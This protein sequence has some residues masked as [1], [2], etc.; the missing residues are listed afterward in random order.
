[1][2]KKAGSIRDRE[3]LGN[4]LY[5][6]A[7]RVAVRARVDA[8]RRK[9]QERMELESEITRDTFQD[10][11][12]SSELKAV[13][14]A[15]LERLPRRYRAPIVLCD[16]EGQT[17]EQAASALRCPVGT[18]KSR[19]SRGRD[20]LRSRLARRGLPAP[21]LDPSS[22]LASDPTSA[23]SFKLL[24][25]TIKA[26]TGL[27]TKGT[28]TAGPALLAQGVI[29]TMAATTPKIASIVLLTGVAAIGGVW[30]TIELG[31][32]EKTSGKQGAI[33]RREVPAQQRD[34]A[35]KRPQPR[36]NQPPK[37]GALR[38]VRLRHAGDCDVAPQAIPNLLEMLSDPP[39]SLNVDL[40]VKDVLPRDP[41]LVYYPLIF[42]HGRAPF[43]FSK[44]DLDTLRQHFDPG[45][46]TLFGDAYLGNTSFDTSFRRMAA[47]L[48]PNNPLVP[49]PKDDDIYTVKVEE[50]LSNVQF[51]KAAGGGRG[52][53]QLEGIKINGHW[54]VIYSKF[55][56]SRALE[57]VNDVNSKGYTPESARKIA[58]NIVIYSTLP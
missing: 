7:R 58:C 44:E 25:Q 35:P 2:V 39:Y 19:L 14:D 37:R 50:D 9:S 49:I 33:A 5:G 30:L 8:R 46:G 22:M 20:R 45:G 40:N 48:F 41:K 18:I 23:I 54:V 1:L 4:W 38:L 24:N 34:A 10:P 31:P 47:E 11:I 12:E 55:D 6:V 21:L 13:V 26:A 42:I 51:T 29:H 43:L 15:E 16:L 17:H 52:F 32:S 27:A 57:G 28:L 53:P 36:R 3:V 56:I